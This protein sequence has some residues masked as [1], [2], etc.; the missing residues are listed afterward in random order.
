MLALFIGFYLREE[1]LKYGS[2]MHLIKMRWG[3]E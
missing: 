3:D 2:C 1:P